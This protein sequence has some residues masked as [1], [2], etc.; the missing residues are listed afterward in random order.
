MPPEFKV[1]IEEYNKE[2]HKKRALSST[3]EEKVMDALKAGF[4]VINAELV[5]SGISR[6]FIAYMVREN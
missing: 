1:V 6:S 4:K 3:F 2:I 5:I